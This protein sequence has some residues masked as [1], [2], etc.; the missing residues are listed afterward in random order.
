ME[1]KSRILKFSLRDCVF[2]ILT[3]KF[4]VQQ[5]KHEI[6]KQVAFYVTLTFLHKVK[7]I[8]TLHRSSK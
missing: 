7:E 1:I 3:G 5:E 8:F 2:C 6:S 4:F